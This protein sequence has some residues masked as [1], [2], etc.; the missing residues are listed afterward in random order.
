MAAAKRSRIY[1]IAGVNGA[2]K[3][4]IGGATFRQ[5]GADYRQPGSGQLGAKL[6]GF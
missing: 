5:R 6:R 1:V 4:S 2:G 3:S